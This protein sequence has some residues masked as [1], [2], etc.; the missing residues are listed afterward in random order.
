MAGKNK[1]SSANLTPNQTIDSLKEDQQW[2]SQQIKSVG[3]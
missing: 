2:A 3:K 1:V